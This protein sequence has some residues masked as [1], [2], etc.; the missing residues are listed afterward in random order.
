[1]Y[2]THVFWN[3]ALGPLHFCQSLLSISLVT[4][5]DFLAQKCRYSVRVSPQMANRMV[6][7]AR[8]ILNKFLPDIYIYTD[9]MKGV[10]SGKWVSRLYR[11]QTCNSTFVHLLGCPDLI[12]LSF[13]SQSSVLLIWN[14]YISQGKK[15]WFTRCICF[16][17]VTGI[18]VCFL[19]QGMQ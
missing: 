13:R 15:G 1:M 14:K 10:N 18:E 7:S 3:N 9:H 19:K 6:E 16:T 5:M 11:K 2:K 12:L 8:G 4:I 17:F